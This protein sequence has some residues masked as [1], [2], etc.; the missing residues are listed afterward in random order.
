[1]RRH[2]PLPPPVELFRAASG[3]FDIYSV[4]RSLP[5]TRGFTITSET[6][7][8]KHRLNLPGEA[9]TFL[10]LSIVAGV[11][12]SAN[13]PDGTV[14]LSIDSD[15]VMESVPGVALADPL[16]TGPCYFTPRPV[17]AT[18]QIDFTFF[19]RS[20]PRNIYVVLYYTEDDMF[21]RWVDTPM[22][23]PYGLLK[24]SMGGGSIV[25]L[26]SKMPRPRG[27]E[28]TSQV[29]QNEH[30]LELDGNARTLLG[31]GWA[32]QVDPPFPNGNMDLLV[33]NTE[34][35]S[36][37]Y[38]GHFSVGRTTAPFHVLSAP[39]F[40]TDNIVLRY[41]DTVSSLKGFVVWYSNANI[42]LP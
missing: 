20:A 10:G 9:K 4:T 31:F 1:M 27:Y 29:G 17:R 12:N 5:K 35:V 14:S 21:R 28:F 25:E 40:G 16:I 34:L 19:D 6:T 15:I 2:V 11:N 23:G 22:N 38:A 42:L 3:N 36:S 7:P 32:A 41:T 26:A 13:I 8:A 37:T 30:E 33:N 39:I 24:A 18:S